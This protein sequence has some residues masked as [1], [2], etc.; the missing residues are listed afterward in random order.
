MNSSS[1]FLFWIVTTSSLLL[2]SAAQNNCI[3]ELNQIYVAEQQTSSEQQ[4][5]YVLCPD[6]TFYPG[7]VNIIQENGRIDD[8]EDTPLVCKNKC[9]IEC[10]TQDCIIDGSRG[11]TYGIVLMPPGVSFDS[12]ETEASEQDIHIEGVTVRNWLDASNQIPIAIGGTA[13]GSITFSNCIFENNE[14]DPLFLIDEL[15]Y[16]DDSSDDDIFNI[17]FT[18]CTFRNNRPSI[19]A[20]TQGGLSL[21]RF[22][23]MVNPSDPVD[24]L[25]EGSKLH[26]TFSKCDFN[27]NM[28]Y[29][30][31]NL[32]EEN[33]SLAMIDF[34]SNGGT[35]T[36]EKN[37]FDGS[38]TQGHG[39]VTVQDSATVINTDNYYT[40]SRRSD[41][42]RRT[43]EFLAIIDSQYKDLQ[44]ECSDYLAES[45]T[46]RPS[47]GFAICF[48]GDTTTVETN[49]G[50]RILMKELKLGDRI[51]VPSSDGT[52]KYETVYS[53]GHRQEI[54]EEAMFLRIFSSSKHQGRRVLEISPQHMVYAIQQ[55]QQQ[56]DNDT[57]LTP[58]FIPAS[59]LRVG[60]Y[61]QIEEQQ[62]SS[63]TNNN[64]KIQSIR[65]IVYENKGVYAPF[66]TSGTFLV[67]NG[68]VVSSFIAFQNEGPTF[69]F[70]YWNTGI[71]HQSIAHSFEFLHR[72][73]CTSVQNCTE[74]NYD[75][76][77]ISTWVATPYKMV[78]SITKY[79]D[80]NDKNN[81][82]KNNVVLYTILIII[83]MMM[84]IVVTASIIIGIMLLL[85]SVIALA[86][87]D[88]SSYHAIKKTTI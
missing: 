68:I 80:T 84:T 67:N 25:L 54:V 26:A 76:N 66:T 9:R 12:E 17:T 50:K 59:M 72:W 63:T 82:T 71:T 7:S 55:Q 33:D 15:I 85:K 86:F 43:C 19:N 3:S 23:G 48:P 60:D 64:M 81:E 13:P 11:G 29:F 62:P 77:G 38:P 21:V 45:L 83:A 2:F 16:D 79:Y 46:C 5:T 75:E 40:D 35:L 37:C 87:D 49:N 73:Y 74:E 44:G 78:V 18:E 4:R 69:R 30:D 28:Y 70:L 88:S 47:G 27:N 36:L 57:I 65:S 51:R 1:A 10:P 42:N 8:G 24:R 41:R 52:P 39:I 58:S 31:E 20:Q 32:F 56:T 53:F 14:A 61:L 34:Y 6:T 22:R